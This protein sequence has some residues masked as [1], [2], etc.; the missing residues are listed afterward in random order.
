MTDKITIE[1][2]EA[3]TVMD[4][5]LHHCIPAP[6]HYDKWDVAV[7]AISAAL[8]QPALAQQPAVLPEWLE[9]AFREGWAS[10]RD[11]EFIGQEAEDWAFGNSFTNSIMIDATQQPVRLNAAPEATAQNSNSFRDAQEA[12]FEQW[13]ET[14]GQFCRAGGGDYEKTF[15]WNA[16]CAAAQKE[17][18]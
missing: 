16:W 13:W 11:S 8:D 9:Q 7:C 18:P 3:K 1:R 17:Q 12:P 4:T 2:A 15:A 6:G 10:C 5:L 14:H